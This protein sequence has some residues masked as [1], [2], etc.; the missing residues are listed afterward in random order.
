MD[1]NKFVSYLVSTVFISVTLWLGYS[2][3]D[4]SKQ[5][6]KIGVSLDY[7]AKSMKETQDA[8]EKLSGIILNLHEKSVKQHYGILEI[9]KRLNRLENE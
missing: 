7:Q 1:I 5:M 9:Q 3:N 6:I 2:V 8:Q 4:M